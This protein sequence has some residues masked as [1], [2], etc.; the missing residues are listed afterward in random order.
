MTNDWRLGGV[1]DDAVTSAMNGRVGRFARC[2]PMFWYQ[3]R[4]GTIVGQPGPDYDD[5]AGVAVA[6][7]WA[8]ALDL[9]PSAEKDATIVGTRTWTGRI[10]GYALEVW[11]ITDRAQFESLCTRQAAK[12]IPA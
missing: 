9:T 1:L 8:A 4:D 7:K 5:D 3:Q 2:Q 6:E 11:C 10:D 12:T